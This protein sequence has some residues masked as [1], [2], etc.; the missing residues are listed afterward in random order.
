LIFSLLLPQPIFCR[1]YHKSCDID[2]T[3]FAMTVLYCCHMTH[4]LA[5]LPQEA[6]AKIDKTDDALFY[7]TPRFVTHIDEAALSA[8]TGFY[9]QTIFGARAVLDLMSSW[10]SHLPT[11]FHGTV[12]GHGMNAAELAANPRLEGYFVQNLNLRPHLAIADAQFDAALCCAGVQY[13][14]QADTVFAEIAR[15]LRPGA[16]FIVSFSNRCFPS[17]AV[18]IWRALDGRGHAELV[19]YYLGRAGFI[20]IACHVL[21]DGTRGDPMTAVI[22]FTNPK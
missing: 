7:A 18:A 20:D 15:V 5:P 6:F 19:E 9:A 22:G 1:L 10:V 2:A 16:P 12:T 17:K 21:S 4:N 14:E 11:S 13:L 3:G 8:L